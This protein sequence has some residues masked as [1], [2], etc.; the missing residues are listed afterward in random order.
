MAAAQGLESWRGVRCLDHSPP[1]AGREDAPTGTGGHDQS[2]REDLLRLQEQLDVSK[3]RVAELTFKCSSQS[4]L[5]SV[6]QGQLDRLLEEA[7]LWRRRAVAYERVVLCQRQ[8]QVLAAEGRSQPPLQ[9]EE[10]AGLRAQLTQALAEADAFRRSSTARGLECAKLREALR[11][12]KSGPSDG[13]DDRQ[14]AGGDA[15]LGRDPPAPSV[16]SFLVI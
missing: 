12:L 8:Q 10:L 5:L 13:R 1:V 3:S 7:R 9:S 2:L 6:R 14:A 16:R 11:R 4:A 15:G